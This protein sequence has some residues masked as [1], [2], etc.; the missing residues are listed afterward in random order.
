MSLQYVFPCIPLSWKIQPNSSDMILI[1]VEHHLLCSEL[2]KQRHSTILKNCLMAVEGA[3]G[4]C[5]LNGYRLSVG[6]DDTFRAS[7]GVFV[8]L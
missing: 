4:E 3:D 1:S 2:L 6:S 8:T 7:G 5:L